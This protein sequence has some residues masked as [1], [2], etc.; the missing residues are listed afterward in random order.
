MD[1]AGKRW[2]RK[3]IIYVRRYAIFDETNEVLNIPEMAKKLGRSE[4]SVKSKIYYL[5]SQDQFPQRIEV[6]GLWLEAYGRPY[7]KAESKRVVS[8][9]NRSY[10]AQEIAESIGRTP[11]S[12]KS[13]VANLKRKGIWL[14]QRAYEWTDERIDVLKDN[15]EFDVYGC[16]DNLDELSSVLGTN[17][18]VIKRKVTKLRKSEEIDIKVKSSSVRSKNGFRVGEALRLHQPFKPQKSDEINSKKVIQVIVEIKTING[19]S[20]T[21]Y[22]TQQ[23]ELLKKE[24]TPVPASV[25]QNK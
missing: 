18:Q 10:S 16:I 6:D 17:P 9:W 23:G 13:Q 22:R 14:K 25:S 4:D 3:E 20:Y 15:I 2:L 21:E 24:P 5:R 7:S 11:S 1:M 12:V 19:K 8:M